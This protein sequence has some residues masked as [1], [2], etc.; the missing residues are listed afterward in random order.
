MKNL[1]FYYFYFTLVLFLPNSA[2]SQDASL[3]NSYEDW[4]V[5][6]IK[7]DSANVCFLSSKAAK[8]EG[9]Y[10]KR[11][12]VLFIVTHRPAK[13][14]IGVINFRTGY[15]FKEDLDAVLTIGKHNF[16][17]FTQG[18]DGWAKDSQTDIAIVKA[19]ISGSQ[20]FINGISSRGTK[21]TDTFSL[22]GFTAAYKAAT[23][24]CKI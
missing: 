3:I 10:S 8:S 16:K 9:N 12:D 24:A 11:G 14:E 5:F 18:S 2:R 4:Y 7:Q 15:T 17:L 19:M 6:T 13:K 21:T 22:K 23:K 20:M 1:I